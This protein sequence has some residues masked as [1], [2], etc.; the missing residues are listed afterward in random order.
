VSAEADAAPIRVAFIGGW[1]RSGS[2]LLAALL[3]E[4]P[5]LVPVGELRYVWDRG[6]RDDELCGCGERFSE[7][8]FW[9]EVGRAAF[10]GW[11]RIDAAEVLALDQ[12]VT[13]HRYLPLMLARRLNRGYTEKLDRYAGYLAR[14]YA[15]IRDVSGS[16]MIVDATK[17]PS[18]AFVLR[19]VPG[20]R[21]NVVHIVR[22]SRGAAFS[23]SKTVAR[24]ERTSGTNELMPQYGALHAGLRWV[25]YNLLFHLVSLVGVKRVFL[26]YEALVSAPGREVERVLRELGSP[27]QNGDLAGI[28]GDS[29]ELRPHH[30]IGGNPMRFRHGRM[31]VRA[32]QA[33]RSAMEPRQ[34]WQVVAVTWPLMLGYG[35]LGA[36]RP[37][38]QTT[39]TQG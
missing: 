20:L 26:R 11:D 32:D 9:Q 21:F 15:G 4:V 14:L 13:R 24:P 3:G 36:G 31:R 12:A 1:G 22:D 7:C 6:L 10:G 38:P 17:D 30:T 29:F 16:D 19:R 2:T 39:T 23:W 5:R 27:P 37:S 8:A 18:Y 34:R 25:A 28:A 33:W 35:Y